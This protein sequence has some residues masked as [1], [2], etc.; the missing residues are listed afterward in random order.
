[1]I[2]ENHVGFLA[3]QQHA[4]RLL[5]ELVVYFVKKIKQTKSNVSARLENSVKHSNI[6]VCL[7][8]ECK[9]FG[10]IVFIFRCF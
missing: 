5:T 2:D 6:F 9:M 7:F 3:V 1:M 8:I 4:D 10:F